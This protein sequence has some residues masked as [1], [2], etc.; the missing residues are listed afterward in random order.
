MKKNCYYISNPLGYLLKEQQITGYELSKKIGLSRGLVSE[1]LSGKK[2]ASLDKI[3]LFCEF[4]VVT[5][6]F[7]TD[8]DSN[9]YTHT[10][11]D[12]HTLVEGIGP[13]EDTMEYGVIPPLYVHHCPRC[14]HVV[15]IEGKRKYFPKFCEECGLSI[16]KSEIPK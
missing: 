11:S 13:A 15:Q 1:Y 2:R 12:N 6:E 16:I 9:I 8:F 10:P 7:F 4:F 5:R 3:D 14:R